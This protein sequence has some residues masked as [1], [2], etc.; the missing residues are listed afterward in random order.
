LKRVKTKEREKKH[1]IIE[2][3]LGLVL[4]TPCVVSLP[5]DIYTT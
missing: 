5:R 1:N 2:P 3:S 4:L